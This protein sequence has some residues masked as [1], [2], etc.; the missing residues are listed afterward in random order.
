MRQGST[1]IV[2]EQK[3]KPMPARKRKELAPHGEFSVIRNNNV[4]PV[5]DASAALQNSREPCGRMH[6]GP[7]TDRGRQHSHRP[8]TMWQPVTGYSAVPSSSRKLPVSGATLPGIHHRSGKPGPQSRP[9]A[10]HGLP[11]SP[12]IGDVRHTR[13]V[14][15]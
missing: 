4:Q 5:L 6:G 9:S 10:D 8:L 14:C 2:T 13:Q 11:R 7:V 1:V 15:G 12:T 3:H